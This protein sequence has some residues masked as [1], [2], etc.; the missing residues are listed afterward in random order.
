MDPTSAPH[1]PE[2]GSTSN[3]NATTGTVFDNTS[4]AT[5]TT[6]RTVES[7]AIPGEEEELMSSAAGAMVRTFASIV[8]QRIP[9]IPAAKFFR[10][11]ALGH[12]NPKTHIP[13]IHLLWHIASGSVLFGVY[14]SAV[15]AMTLKAVSTEN[16][17]DE[18]KRIAVWQ[19]FLGGGFSGLAHGALNN[20]SFNLHHTQHLPCHGR[21]AMMTTWTNSLRHLATQRKTPQLMR[22]F[23]A[24]AVSD[25]LGFAMFFGTYEAVRL[26]LDDNY[27]SFAHEQHIYSAKTSTLTTALHAAAAGCLA[28]LALEIVHFPIHQAQ[29]YHAQ[30]HKFHTPTRLVPIG[31][32]LHI[33]KKHGAL[34]AYHNFLSAA[35]RAL[36]SSA[37]AFL[38]YELCLLYLSRL[39]D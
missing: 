29:L 33:F 39:A 13:K 25:G 23:S 22:G 4:S 5:V 18:S 1:V 36:P 7:S 10:P 37:L 21:K 16:S 35:M 27:R 2:G 15:R 3:V 17:N 19:S 14:T 12:S 24:A 26:L 6:L 32:V 34:F 20:L 31:E 8:V 30:T 28:G 11:K 38:G 9:H